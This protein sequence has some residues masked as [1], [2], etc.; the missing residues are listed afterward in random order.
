MRMVHQ[1]RPLRIPQPRVG[2]QVYRME[3][4]DLEVP[5]LELAASGQGYLDPLLARQATPLAALRLVTKDGM[6]LRSRS[7]DIWARKSPVYLQP[8][9]D[10][11]R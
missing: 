3:S 8:T 11:F 6:R 5:A 4:P 7:Q 9:P 10:W 1:R 2:T